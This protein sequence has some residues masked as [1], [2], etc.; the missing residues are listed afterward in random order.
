M[1]LDLN[2]SF[3]RSTCSVLSAGMV[4]CKRV[5]NWMYALV[6]H[7]TASEPS[8]LTNFTTLKTSDVSAYLR[9]PH[10][11]LGTNCRFNDISVSQSN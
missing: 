6:V 7:Y 11:M 2:C 1:L 10:C 9:L 4:Y 3:V 8:V 5:G